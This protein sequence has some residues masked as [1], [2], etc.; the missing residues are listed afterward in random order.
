MSF[1]KPKAV[2]SMLQV[3]GNAPQQV[4]GK[5]Q[6]PCCASGEK[7]IDTRIGTANTLMRKN[8]QKPQSCQFSKRYS[9]Q[10]SHMIMKFE[11]WLEYFIPSASGWDAIFV[12]S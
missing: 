12:K 4:E 8:F 11:Y 5:V 6:M 9:F 1:Q 10:S 2:H 7:N 3:S